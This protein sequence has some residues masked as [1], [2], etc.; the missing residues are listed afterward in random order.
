MQ[1]RNWT[2][3]LFSSSVF[4]LLLVASWPQPA[5]A[6]AD[7]AALKLAYTRTEDRVTP[8]SAATYLQAFPKTGRD[9]NRL[10]SSSGK[11]GDGLEYIFRLETIAARAST[12]TLEVL[13]GLAA[14]L[15]W[16]PGAASYLQITL[17]KIA[18]NYTREFARQVKK[19]SRARQLTLVTFLA[20]GPHS[21][22]P[23]YSQ[24]AGVLKAIDE[25]PLAQLLNDVELAQPRNR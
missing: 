8:R 18:L 20:S 1:L 23:G 5:A 13:L 19:L 7:A 14:E 10:F 21:A 24:L 9:F 22:A 4:L 17:A 2:P 15:R 6:R 3:S 16:Q 25:A 12:E 11:L